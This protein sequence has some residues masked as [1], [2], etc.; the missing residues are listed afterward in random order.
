MR[1]G[2]W[3]SLSQWVQLCTWSPNK[4]WRYNSIF[5]ICLW[6]MHC[7]RPPKKPAKILFT[8]TACTVECNGFDLFG[9]MENADL[10]IAIFFLKAISFFS[11]SD[12]IWLQNWLKSANK[13][14]W[15]HILPRSRKNFYTINVITQAVLCSCKNG[16]PQIY[17]PLYNVFR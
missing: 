1:G 10:I 8:N 2:G 12:H 9:E 3:R 14:Y 4:L 17:F 6:V 7:E 15:F 13:K 11:F 5:N 16:K